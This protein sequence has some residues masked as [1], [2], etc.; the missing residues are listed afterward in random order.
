MKDLTVRIKIVQVL[1]FGNCP[2]CGGLHA[3]IKPY[4]S[5]CG[6]DIKTNLLENGFNL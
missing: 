6:F 1:G 4:C 3:E 2:K 5:D